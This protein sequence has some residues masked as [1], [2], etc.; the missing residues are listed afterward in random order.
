MEIDNT[1]VGGYSGYTNTGSYNTALGSGSL[2]SNTTASNNTAIG[3]F[4]SAAPVYAYYRVMIIDKVAGTHGNAVMSAIV[5][6]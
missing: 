6:G 4:A 3:Y 5:K 1:F 2:Y